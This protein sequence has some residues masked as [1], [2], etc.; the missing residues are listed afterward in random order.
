[1]TGTPVLEVDE[2]GVRFG[3]VSAVSSVSFSVMSG[4]VFGIVGESGAGKSASAKA[5]IGLLPQ[6]ARVRGSVKF[7]GQQLV[8][9]DPST[10]RGVRGAGIGYVFQDALTA[11]DP[12]RRVGVQLI[13]A[14]QIHKDVGKKEASAAAEQLLA[15]VRIKDPARCMQS[16]PHQ[17]SGGMRQRVV[18]AAALIADPELIIADEIT[19]ALDVTVQRSV[20]DLL[21]DV[22]ASRG[23]A[24]ILITHD[25][26]VVAQTCD[27]VAVLYGGIVVEQAEIFELFDTPR[28]PYT[29]ALM[30]SMPRIG[31]DVPFV[32]IPGSS[33]Q[34]VG[35]LVTCPFSPRC[36]FVTD[37]CLDG[38]PAVERAD[39]REVRCV[40]PLGLGVS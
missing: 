27:R 3:A 9:A 11:L 29:K 15:E 19:S 7:K 14:L 36:S 6:S 18:I 24:V 39:S 31:E 30:E 17:L 1:M 32:P 16:Y 20:L 22:C 25:L 5:I 40:H 10:L 12:V 21:L 2:L 28:H 37:E 33:I 13:E 34:V 38:I 4:E 23:A 26:G 8:G 35:E